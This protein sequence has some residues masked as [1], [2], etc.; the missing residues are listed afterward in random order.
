VSLDDD[1]PPL[2]GHQRMRDDQRERTQLRR[3]WR[4]NEYDIDDG[5]PEAIEA[6]MQEG[7]ARR[8][9]DPARWRDSSVVETVDTRSFGRTDPANA[10]SWRDAS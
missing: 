9:K 5:S 1:L 10:D 7:A 4:E 3:D 6:M 8:A 2:V